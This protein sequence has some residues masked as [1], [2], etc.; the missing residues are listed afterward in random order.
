MLQSSG[1]IW[2]VMTALVS[3]VADAPETVFPVLML[4][5]MSHVLVPSAIHAQRS[6]PAGT[7]LVGGVRTMVNVF[8][9]E[10]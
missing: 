5:E 4:Q 6:T 10:S 7:Q 2:I 1:S 3:F 9:V 8:V